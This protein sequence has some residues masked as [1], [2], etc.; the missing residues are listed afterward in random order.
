MSLAFFCCLLV[1]KDI[2]SFLL[3]A[4]SRVPCII[5][6]HLGVGGNQSGL[7]LATACMDKGPAEEA[8]K[9]KAAIHHPC[10][11]LS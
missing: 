8:H 4:R 11:P 1:G 2:A 6:D 3:T 9:Q 10:N 7:A 5:A